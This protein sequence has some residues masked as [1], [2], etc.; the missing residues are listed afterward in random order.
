MGPYCRT[1]L[2]PFPI[3]LTAASNLYLSRVDSLV[4]ESHP[5]GPAPSLSPGPVLIAHTLANLLFMPLPRHPTKRPHPFR[6]GTDRTWTQSLAVFDHSTMLAFPVGN[7][8]RKSTG[9]D[10]RASK[11]WG[12][13]RHP[14]QRMADRSFGLRRP[15]FIQ[16]NND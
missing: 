5:S 12:Q 9:S 2:D 7:A 4:E 14:H 3:D 1:A 10:C 13:P 16:T 8:I 15:V 11:C 6:M